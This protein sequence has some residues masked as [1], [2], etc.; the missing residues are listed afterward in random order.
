MYSSK[1]HHR[2][3]FHFHFSPMFTF[4][5]YRHLLRT[6]TSRVWSQRFSSTSR[7][8]NKRTKQDV[9]SESL[10]GKYRNGHLWLYQT[11]RKYHPI[12]YSS[13]KK[14]G[15]PPSSLTTIQMTLTLTLKP[16]SK[17]YSTKK[18]ASALP[19]HTNPSGR[20]KEETIL[21]NNCSPGSTVDVAGCR[22]FFVCF[23]SHWHS[24]GLLSS[25]L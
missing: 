22:N 14:K 20:R 9:S 19:C 12:L 21:A 3:I 11:G 17:H 24:W 10:H 15:I 13:K 8:T 16:K 6:Y 4:L 1:P 18:P 25:L 7:K 5:Y 2:L 23:S